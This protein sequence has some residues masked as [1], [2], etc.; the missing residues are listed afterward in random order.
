LTLAVVES[1][2][3]RSLDIV[4]SFGRFGIFAARLLAASVGAPFRFRRLLGD[5]YNAG[6]QSLPVI[7]SSG[8]VVGAVL[9]V[10]GYST[11]VRFGAEEALGALVGLAVVRELGPVF[12]ALLVTG[13][14][15]SAFAAEV[16]T[17]VT[18]EQTD[19]LEMMSIDP[20][21]FVYSPK[22]LALLFVM[23]LLSALFIVF[24]IGGGYWIS[25]TLLGF[26]GGTFVSSLESAVE[27]SDM[28]GSLIKTVVF[29]ALAGWIATYR[30]SISERTAAGVNASTTNTVVFTSVSV[31]VF[32]LIIDFFLGV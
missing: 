5:V 2:G 29:G 16:A 32:D 6:V 1:I 13:R 8:A 25:I 31:L 21:D 12:T 23:P 27:W 17:M 4:R 3:A 24:S 30:G 18:T 10:L 7:C 28:R 26:D 11:L 19:G 15:G 9:S 20:V 22:A 14:A